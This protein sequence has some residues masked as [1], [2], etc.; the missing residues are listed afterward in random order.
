MMQNMGESDTARK[1]QLKLSDVQPFPVQLT[2][3]TIVTEGDRFVKTHFRLCHPRTSRH[4]WVR[5]NFSVRDLG[6][7]LQAFNVEIDINLKQAA[8]RRLYIG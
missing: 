5:V 7:V 6:R 8:S 1:D 2:V 3:F 4:S